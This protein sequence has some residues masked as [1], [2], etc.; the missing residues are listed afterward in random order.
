MQV[1]VNIDRKFASEAL[2]GLQHT[3]TTILTN[4]YIE[5]VIQDGIIFAVDVSTFKNA[6]HCE[7]VNIDRVNVWHWLG[8]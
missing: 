7:W 6:V 5:W 3:T 2:T 8:Y 1:R 4:H